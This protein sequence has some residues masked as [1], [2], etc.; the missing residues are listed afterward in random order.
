MFFNP[1][2]KGVILSEALADLSHIRELMAR[3]R[4]TPAGLIS[5]MLLGAFRAESQEQDLLR[6]VPDGHG[7][8]FSY[9]V[10]IFHPRSVQDPG[11]V[12]G[13]WKTPSS[14]GEISPSGVLRLRA[15]IAVSCRKSV[16]RSA[17]DDDFVAS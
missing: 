4:R 7:Y 8:M 9:T 13:G 11:A 12:F 15:T 6:Y 1:F 10:T 2:Q 17:Q 16:R 14:I 3:S 5:P